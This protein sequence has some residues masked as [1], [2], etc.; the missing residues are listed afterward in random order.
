MSSDVERW[1]AALNAAMDLYADFREP[2]AEKALLALNQTLKD[3]MDATALD[4]ERHFFRGRIQVLL[5]EPQQALLQF[6]QALQLDADHE[7]ALWET[8][9]LLLETLDRPEG[10]KAIVEQRLIPLRPDSE[11]YREALAAAE[12]LIRRRVSESGTAVSAD[13]EPSSEEPV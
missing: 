1:E 10:A 8:A 7:G 9:A 5:E 13:A 4:A 6:E 3:G 11:T 12:T 2:E